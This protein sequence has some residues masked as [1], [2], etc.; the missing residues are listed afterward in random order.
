MD[1]GAF[2]IFLIHHGGKHD[3]LLNIYDEVR[4]VYKDLYIG[5]NFLGVPANDAYKA[6]PDT[7]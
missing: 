6:L 3:S 2:G 7:C 4:G 5:M 1:N